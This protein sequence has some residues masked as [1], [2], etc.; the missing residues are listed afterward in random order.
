MSGLIAA[1]A[2]SPAPAGELKPEEAKRFVAEKLFS[3]TCSNGINGGGWIH[4]D[5]SVVGTIQAGSGPDRHVSL[6]SGTI[7]L[8]SDSICA[9]LR[10]AMFQPCFNVVQTSPLSF[11]GS[12][13]GLDFAYCDFV[14]RNAS[15]EITADEGSRRHAH[16]PLS[17][18]PS[19][20]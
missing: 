18:L 7:R 13:R 4:S 20:Y 11:R 6:P 10:G 19:R 16:E 12:I 3:Y 14:H 15:V 8:T 17:L 9:S 2:F 5:G 1:A